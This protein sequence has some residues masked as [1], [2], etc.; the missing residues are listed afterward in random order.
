MMSVILGI[1]ALVTGY[2]GMNIP[3]LAT[4]LTHGA[5]SIWSLVLT[6]LMAVASLWFIVYIV[7]S[8]WMDYRASILPHRYRK[9]ISRVNL[10]RLIRYD[11]EG[12]RAPK[13]SPGP[14]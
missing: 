11:G 8:N 5:L 1:G 12:L 4:V 6:S 2:Y 13:D 10:R 3:H 7:A 9:A 14:R